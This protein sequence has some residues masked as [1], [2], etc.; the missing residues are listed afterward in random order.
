[1]ASLQIKQFEC[2]S[3]N[4]GVLIHDADNELTAA[5]DAPDAAQVRAALAGAGWRLTH[6]L[7][8]HHHH[9]HTD[10]NIALK[11][12]TG[13]TIVGPRGGKIPGLDVEVGEGDTF[14]FGAFAAKIVE[15][16][17]HTLDH[18]CYW[19]EGERVAFVGDTL[20]ALGCGRV[21]EGSLEQMWASLQKLK[22]LP[23]D[24]LIYCGHEYT[25]AN[26]QFA[27]SV[28][29]GNEALRARAAEVELLRNAG[30]ATLPTRLD[31]ELA[32][33]PFLRADAPG[34]QQA[35]NL[36]GGDPAAVFAEVRRR[37]DRF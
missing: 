31:I 37:K 14:T 8:T 34:V 16:P 19:F 7:N 33:N 23:L 6:I 24:T 26:A 4:Y 27:L 11:E 29:P 2:L 5:I 10:G 17:G 13:C 18:I 9:D 30:R 21:L 3:D 12:E 15:T 25:L 1:M 36:P 32:T 22:K 35:V 20:F 28:D